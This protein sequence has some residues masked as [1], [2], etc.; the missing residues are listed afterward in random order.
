LPNLDTE[1]L[2]YIIQNNLPPEDYE[3][4][5]TGAATIGD[6]PNISD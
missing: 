4:L 1:T 3:K 2:C 6:F 5:L